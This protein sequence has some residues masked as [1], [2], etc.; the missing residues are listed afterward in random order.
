M[1]FTRRRSDWHSFDL[2]PVAVLLL[3]AGGF[4][5]S[6]S[7][8]NQDQPE[9]MD[10]ASEGAIGTDAASE[11]PPDAISNASTV[12]LPLPVVCEASP[13]ATSLVTTTPS[14]ASD[15]GEGFCALLNDGAVACWGANGGGQ[16]GRGDDAG[17][18]D[19]V[20]AARVPGVSE[21]T[22]LD[23]TCAIDKS[24]AAWCWGTGPYLQT[25]AEAI[26]TERAPVKLPIPPAANVSVGSAAGCAT[27]DEGVLCWGANTYAQVAPLD[28]EPS[29][30][31]LAPRAIALPP[32]GSIRALVVG[33]ASFLFRD[34]ATLSWGAMPPLGRATPFRPD[35][36]PLPLALAG[37]SMVDV[38]NDNACAVAGGIGYCWG[39]AVQRPSD[40]FG[41]T[42][43]LDRALPEAVFTPEPITQIATSG[44]T[45]WCASGGSGAVYCWGDNA[46]GQAGDGTK[47]FAGRAV[48]VAGLP[49]P[50]AQVKV[51]PDATCALLTSGK[52][53]C[54]GSN[55]YGQ[56]G[57][58]KLK[59]PSVVPQEVVLP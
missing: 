49:G 14:S 4:V 24:G 30:A 31:V 52:V 12:P 1:R 37:I 47:T 51:M 40:Q 15:R 42:P 53:Y 46:T 21:I 16:L 19:S 20:T 44:P 32:G 23:H 35:P 7:S 17:V 36:H 3:A 57:S 45:R 56:L 39:V 5:A 34:D 8:D 10:A 55:F 43:P 54:W 27:V 25:D 13:C 6:C 48:T 22:R 29:S 2:P 18:D 26:T 50:A 33:N 59:T 58:G 11:M 41:G 28:E 38:V 9:A